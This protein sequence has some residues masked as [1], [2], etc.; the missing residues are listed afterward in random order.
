MFIAGQVILRRFEILKCN[1]YFGTNRVNFLFLK[2]PHCMFYASCDSLLGS[3]LEV[4]EKKKKKT[5][6]NRF[7]YELV[8]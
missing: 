7:C 8:V 6:K 4:I 2:I 5:K 1:A 3:V